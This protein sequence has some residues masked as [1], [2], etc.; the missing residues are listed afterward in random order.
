MSFAVEVSVVRRRL[1][2]HV[3]LPTER[4]VPKPAA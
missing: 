4:G 1:N 2:V 3:Q